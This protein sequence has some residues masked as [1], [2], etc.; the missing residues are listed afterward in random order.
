[1]TKFL[2]LLILFYILSFSQTI[3]GEENKP[4][5][6]SE[7]NNLP[8]NTEEVKGMVL[9]KVFPHAEIIIRKNNN[10]QPAEYDLTAS[11]DRHSYILPLEFNLL[12]SGNRN[13]KELK[14]EDIAEAFAFLRFAVAGEKIQINKPIEKSL[15][16]N[17]VL[18]NYTAEI[19][20]DGELYDIYFNIIENIIHET[21]LFKAGK[22]IE[23]FYPSLPERTDIIFQISGVDPLLDQGVNH[24]YFSVEENGAP[25]NDTIRFNF[26]GLEPN[27][28]NLVLRVVPH[29]GEHGVFNLYKEIPVN[30]NGEASY[31]WMPFVDTLT[32]FCHVSLDIDGTI[33]NF[34]TVLVVPEKTLTGSFPTGYDYTIF[35][36]NQVF[37][38]HPLGA[39]HADE[40]AWYMLEGLLESWDYQV[41]QWKVSAGLLNDMPEDADGNYWVTVCDPQS[42]YRHHLMQRSAHRGGANRI[43]GIGYNGYLTRSYYSSELMQVKVLMSHEFLHGIQYGHNRWLSDD[44]LTEGQAVA[45]TSIQY[46]EEEFLI[47]ERRSFNRTV[48]LYMRYHLNRSIQVQ[49]YPFGVYW[50][51]LYENYKQGD[52]K[53]KI[54]I[55]RRTCAAC[56]SNHPLFVKTGMN[57]ALIE[58][59][60]IYNSFTATI[61]DFARNIYFNDPKYTLWS[62]CPTDTFYI[63]PV[64]T[65]DEDEDGYTAWL[66]DGDYFI[67]ENVN[68]SYGSDYLLFGLDGN[69]K[70]VTLAFSP[71]TDA[72]GIC[73]LF[74]IR[75]VQL[76]END[77]I[78]GEITEPAGCLFEET[79][80]IHNECRKLLVILTRTDHNEQDHDGE[81]YLRIYRP[82]DLAMVFDRSVYSEG[83]ALNKAKMIGEWAVSSLAKGDDIAITSYN[84]NFFID[85]S[86]STILEAGD[87]EIVINAIGNIAPAGEISLGNGVQSGLNQLLMSENPNSGK[88]VILFNNGPHNHPPDPVTIIQQFGNDIPISLVTSGAEADQRLSNRVAELTGGV[89]HYAGDTLEILNT[90]LTAVNKSRGLSTEYIANHYLYPGVSDLVYH[91]F[92][93][94]EG[95]KSALL[96]VSWDDKTLSPP[97]ILYSNDNTIIEP[98]SAVNNFLIDYEEFP[99]QK[100]YRLLNPEPG[101]WI[102]EVDAAAGNTA[103]NIVTSS[104]YND[105]FEIDGGTDKYRYNMSDSILVSASLFYEDDPVTNGLILLDYKRP[106]DYSQWNQFPDTLYDDGMHGDGAADDAV[107]ANYIDAGLVEGSISC[108]LDNFMFVP[109]VGMVRRQERFSAY[110]LPRPVVSFAADTIDFG[111]VVV[112]EYLDIQNEISNLAAEPASSLIIRSAYSTTD[113]FDV[114]P[115]YLN[116]APGDVKNITVRFSPSNADSFS[117]KILMA[118]ND[119]DYPE[120]GFFVRG[121]GIN[122]AAISMN[123]E[124]LQAELNLADTLDTEIIISNGGDIPLRLIAMAEG[125]TTGGKDFV[126]NMYSGEMDRNSST[127]HDLAF[128]KSKRKELSN[129]HRK[130]SEN[131]LFY[132]NVESGNAGWISVAYTGEDL[133]HITSMN[134]RSGSYS[135]RLGIKDQNT[136]NNQQRINNALVSQKF[137]LPAEGAFISFFE[138]YDTEPGYDFC[139]V[140]VSTDNGN[141][142]IHLRG[143]AVNKTAPSGSSGGW[144]FSS[145]DLSLFAGETILLRFYFDTGD[146]ISQDYLG[147]FIDDIT[148]S[149]GSMNPGWIKLTEN[150][151]VVPPGES[152]PLELQFISAGF[153]PGD[154]TGNIWISSNDPLLPMANVP[155]EMTILSTGSFWQESFTVRDGGAFETSKELLFGQSENATDGIDEVLGEMELPPQPPAGV[156]DA[157]FI[158]PSGM[159]ASV[160]DFR[161]SELDSIDWQ[162]NFQPGDAGYPFTFYWQPEALPEGS[163]RIKDLFGGQILNLNMKSTDSLLIDNENL[164]SVKIEFRKTV[165]GQIDVVPGWNLVSVP[166]ETGDMSVLSLFSSDATG[167]YSYQSGYLPEDTLRA[168]E[169]YWIKFSEP[170]QYEVCG[171]SPFGP[172]ALDEGWNIIGPYNFDMP[173]DQIITNPVNILLTPFYGFS[174]GYS[175]ANILETGKA[176]WIKVSEAGEII[177]NSVPLK[178]GG[179]TS[180]VQETGK[181]WTSLLISDNGG[182][183]NT[184]Y[185]TGEENINSGFELPPMPP[186][187]APDIRFANGKCLAF[188][189]QSVNEIL[190]RS[191]LFPLEVKVDGPGIELTNDSGEKFLL[192]SGEKITLAENTGKLTVRSIDTPESFELYQNYPNPFNSTTNIK[193]SIP[194]NARVSVVVFNI[195]GEKLH[196][197][198]KGEYEAGYYHVIF[199][200]EEMSS[201]VYLYKLI[202]ESPQ[203]SFI[204]TKKMMLIK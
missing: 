34:D 22:R 120:A 166:V 111:E 31:T 14:T 89:Y 157:R 140:D 164:N 94:D 38:Q 30:E 74:N 137:E 190:L 136:Y 104:S 55:F 11:A 82:T 73:A 97:V 53:D 42:A 200:P 112:G 203:G 67:S 59:G 10:Y 88:S 49:T 100:Y 183:R 19:E 79:L 29:Y 37:T 7:L 35:F 134:S 188:S 185:I 64:L 143:D 47:P 162:I 90:T 44:W 171:A 129:Y 150:I 80:L 139:M 192:Q 16:Y 86:L 170:G 24:Y 105:L 71:D 152:L 18:F 40:F 172:V 165:C 26:K 21:M 158:L 4:D 116:I 84:E 36:N 118:T 115:G 56:S 85:H 161:N 181:D 151:L 182:Y 77:E 125:N 8:G 178:E 144:I 117:A 187:G 96:S 57:T 177:Y 196:T 51:F 12:L 160:I 101:G 102:I 132:D 103:M 148:I 70:R 123:P 127:D 60:G 87:K 106:P 33:H 122:P 142:W 2:R 169:G 9:S 39:E 1:M 195:L 63:E 23:L 92:R 6:D 65:G 61:K 48:N 174:N 69:E 176:Y 78:V 141:E 197:I 81:Y 145:L 204:R 194:W 147:W 149:E 199:Q 46:P 83:G 130:N 25:T 124:Q 62:P 108:R 173:V 28:D 98:D 128:T 202:A 32:G 153:T 135:W 95:V 17:D 155:A 3:A 13:Y 163:F 186:E 54:D 91:N 76:T 154:Y 159:E 75:L 167:A 201:G 198:E 126:N 131:I 133:W 41:D 43:I 189:G 191:L 93:I 138:S 156:F 5:N 193:F 175:A 99:G 109:G 119:P 107:Y 184:L 168:G 66:S 146:A 52:I 113:Q 27:Q 15:E 110:V 45:I 180:I 20:C 50:R 68:V 121:T 179:K 58:G 114:F 72:D